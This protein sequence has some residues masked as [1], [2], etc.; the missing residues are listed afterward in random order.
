MNGTA[1]LYADT[2]TASMQEAL[3]ETKRRREKQEAYNT[4]HG[5][6]PASIKKNIGDILESVYERDHVTLGT[7]V[8][9]I[10]FSPKELK[11]KLK[12]LER[13]MRKAA[14][15]LN[16]EEAAKLRDQIRTLENDDL[17]V[18]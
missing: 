15:D 7:Q 17:S 1:I 3:G 12:E 13:A 5:I 11:K 2:I 10:T 16:F 4:E 18:R 8:G 9:G 14:D 6:T